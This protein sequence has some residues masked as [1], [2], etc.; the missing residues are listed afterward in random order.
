[1]NGSNAATPRF[2][3][4]TS[5]TSRDR[6]GHDELRDAERARLLLLEFLMALFRRFEVNGR[7]S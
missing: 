3:T 4:M 2:P 6:F 5:P 7:T 1:M